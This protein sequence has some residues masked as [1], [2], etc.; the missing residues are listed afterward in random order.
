MSDF[1]FIDN[2]PDEYT[3]RRIR[4]REHYE[5]VLRESVRR[6][7]KHLQN[8]AEQLQDYCRTMIRA[9]FDASDELKELEATGHSALLVAAFLKREASNG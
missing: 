3:E 4:E 2:M 1:A 5:D 6:K 7:L 9:G 8:D